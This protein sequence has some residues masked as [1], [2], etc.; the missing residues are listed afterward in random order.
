VDDDCD[1]HV[2]CDDP[3][4]TTIAVCVPEVTGPFV[5]GT[6]LDPISLCP[7]SYSSL[8]VV[9]SGLNAAAPNCSTG[10]SC[11][12][13]CFTQL[14]SFGNA[15]NCPNTDNENQFALINNTMCT[16]WNNWDGTLDVHQLTTPATCQKNGTPVLPTVSWAASKRVCSTAL[17]GGGCAP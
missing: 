17:H 11:G 13:S 3:D 10:C 15:A 8:E 7:Q 16:S 1:G 5:V 2:D 9:N 12:V 14:Y 6:T 4:C